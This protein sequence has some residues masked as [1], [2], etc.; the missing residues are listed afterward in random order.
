V[1]ATEAAKSVSLMPLG[2]LYCTATTYTRDVTSTAERSTPAACATLCKYCSSLN[3]EAEFK[4]NFDLKDVIGLASAVVVAV[5]VVTLPVALPVVVVSFVVLAV[6]LFAELVAA[7]VVVITFPLEVVD[8]VDSFALGVV[9]LFEAA[10]VVE[11][12]L[13]STGPPPSFPDVAAD[14]GAEDGAD[15]GATVG[16][17]AGDGDAHTA[18]CRNPRTKTKR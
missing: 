7:A 12:V 18:R 15:V 13:T 16:A 3:S 17:S 8:A 2:T 1:L 6:L 9:E 14:V 4:P 11:D 10:V 5:L